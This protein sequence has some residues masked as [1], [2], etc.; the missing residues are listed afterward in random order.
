MISMSSN[1]VQNRST[2]NEEE[3]HVRCMQG[4][5]AQLR[6]MA[7]AWAAHLAALRALA[8]GSANAELVGDFARHQ[9]ERL[10]RQRG[11]DERNRATK[12]NAGQPAKT[13]T[14]AGSQKTARADDPGPFD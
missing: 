8:H 2:V 11:E 3:R 14:R 5:D 12:Q 1:M 7:A 10:H 13:D 4:N 6:G 9:H